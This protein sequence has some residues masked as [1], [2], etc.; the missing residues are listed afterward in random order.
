MS[1]KVSRRSFIFLPAQLAALAALG[2]MVRVPGA[3]AEPAFSLAGPDRVLIN[4]L[5]WGMDGANVGA[6]AAGRDAFVDRQFKAGSAV[7][8]AA[9]Q[10]RMDAMMLSS[11][12]AEELAYGIRAEQLVIRD[13]PDGKAKQALRKTLQGRISQLQ[14]ETMERSLLR[15]LYSGHQLQERLTWFWCNHFSI[16]IRK[17]PMMRALVADFEERAVRPHVFGRFE[18]MLMATVRHPA[19]L[20]YLDNARNRAGQINENYGRE[21]MELHT[22]GV[23]GNYTQEDVT[24]LTRTLTGLGLKLT[25]GETHV[26]RKHRQAYVSDG[27]FQFHPA[28]HDDGDKTLLG[29]RIR[30]GGMDEVEAVIRLLARHPSTARHL[31]RKLATYFVSDEPPAAVVDAMASTYLHEDGNLSAVLRTMLE[32]RAFQESLLEEDFKDPI[33][34]VLGGVRLLYSEADPPVLNASLLV[35]WLGM[36]GE[37]PFAR[38]TPDG[39]PIRRADW[40]GSGQMA[41][42]FDV[43]RQMSA[44]PPALFH[45]EEPPEDD[46]LRVPTAGKKLYE[47]VL[48]RHARPATREALAKARNP[49]EWNE[50]WL[51]SPDFMYA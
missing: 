7:F 24:A 12:S 10:K 8:P 48:S 21:L 28:R 40:Q 13:A 49:R 18:D 46:E 3:R 23:G 11:A 19:M 44:G 37:Q 1:S 31:S 39:Y 41:A 38:D 17:S 42:R 30:A 2:G 5:T 25:E 34:Y 36:L 33:R 16:S 45:G 29:R 4:R 20:A 9:V 6:F 27:L 22:L 14:R 50:L 26:S 35:R 47:S 32:H 43:A 51:A 15:C